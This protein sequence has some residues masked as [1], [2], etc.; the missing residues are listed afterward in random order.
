MLYWHL[1]GD[2]QSKGYNRFFYVF[3]QY[4]VNFVCMLSDG[5]CAWLKKLE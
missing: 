3:K 5:L 1:L 4:L 2:V